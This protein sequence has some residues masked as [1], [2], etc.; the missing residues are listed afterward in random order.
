MLKMFGCDSSSWIRKNRTS[1]K[2]LSMPRAL[3]GEIS[4]F[5]VIPVEP[6]NDNSKK[7]HQKDNSIQLRFALYLEE[8]IL[9]FKFYQGYLCQSD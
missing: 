6:Q 9:A 1:V 3:G 4:L 8:F 7:L 5:F 2:R